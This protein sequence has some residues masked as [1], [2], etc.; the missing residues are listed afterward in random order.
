M[1]RH[2]LAG[3]SRRLRE[4]QLGFSSLAD[5]R[6]FVIGCHDTMNGVRIYRSFVPVS[7]SNVKVGYLIESHG[8]WNHA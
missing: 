3:A 7:F 2:I 5:N 8:A 6:T 4:Y 1:Q